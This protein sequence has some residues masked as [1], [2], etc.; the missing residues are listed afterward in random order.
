MNYKPQTLTHA[1]QLAACLLSLTVV[2][3]ASPIV[4]AVLADESQQAVSTAASPQVSQEDLPDAATLVTEVRGKL[5]GL[6]SLSCDL[7]ETILVSGMKF[8]AAGRY[9]QA[10]GNRFRLEFRI[11]PAVGA[12]NQNSQ[13]VALDGEI[14]EDAVVDAKGSLTQVS[15][16]SILYT[17]WLNG[18]DTRVTR[19]NISEILK[20][21]SETAAYDSTRAVQDLGLGGLKTLFARFQ[22]TMEFSQV[23]REVV[24]STQFL[25]VNGRWNTR[26]R[27]ELFQMPDD[28]EVIPQEFIPEYVRLYV[29]EQTR[30]PRRIQ[31]LKRSLDPAQKLVRPIVTLD[32]RQIV[33]NEQLGDEAFQFESP[34]G[35]VEEDITEQTLQEIRQSA[36]PQGAAQPDGSADQGPQ[37]GG[38][39]A[40]NPNP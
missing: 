7:H 33:L 9:L 16:G 36:T 28:A 18:T 10:S 24:G 14:S 1:S 8:S 38:E 2:L 20:V 3:A 31:Y 40:V 11:M 34:E 4:A 29:D 35:V 30:L 25:V 39:P 5:D 21:A 32:L 22:N 15:N 26:I 13:P 37:T 6:D 19:R 27:K 17:Y 12:S 23:R